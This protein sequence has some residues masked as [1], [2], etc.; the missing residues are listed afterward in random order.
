MNTKSLLI[1]NW[2][3]IGT[4]VLFGLSFWPFSD[5]LPPPS[6]SLTATQL[7]AFYQLHAPG[8][9]FGMVL[10]MFAA[11]LNCVFVAVIATQLR[12]IETVNPVWTYTQIIAGGLGSATI[13][14]GAMLMTA[15]VFRPERAPDLTY[16]MSD[17]S[18]LW[19]VMP[20]TPAV[21]QTF[22][23]G[24][25]ILLDEKTPAI[26]PRWLGYFNV[27]AAIVYIPGCC[28]TFFK[29]GPLA[30]NGILALW[31]PAG[32]FSVWFVVMFVMLRKAILQQ[33]TP[34]SQ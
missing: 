21:I 33:A 14:I 8:I 2:A 28:V 4:I 10:M 29:T 30:W 15:T 32:V 18:W 7:A 25:A 9:R 34:P 17:I 3:G 22:A 27:W 13:I 19:I 12:R 26:F 24:F 6:P 11:S 1:A 23:V 16:L 20:G 5:F 31:A